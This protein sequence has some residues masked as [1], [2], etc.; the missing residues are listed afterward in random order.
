MSKFIDTLNKLTR[1]ESTPI[2][3]RRDQAASMVRKIQ[4]V[5]LVSKGEADKSGADTVLLDVREK[6]IE[7]ESVS[8]MPGD[9]PWGAWLKGARQK[10]LKQLKDA[11]CDFIVFPA[12]STPL[13]IIEVQDIGKVLEIDTAISDSVLR[14]IVELPIDAVLVSVGLGNVNSLTWYDLM[15]LQRLGGLPKKPLL[16]H[17]P[18]KIS[19]GELEA[20]WEA[21]VM[22]V[23]TEGNIDKLRKTIDKAD[24]TKARKREKN[25]PIIRQVSDS[26]IEDDY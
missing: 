18:V 26:D 2:G 4:L 22:A 14:S 3:F 7:P 20:L 1:L 17:I 25:E 5:S 21:G 23:I 15:I 12:E 13:E 9:I 24:F 16:A 6:G 11:G 10:D 8:G 19:S